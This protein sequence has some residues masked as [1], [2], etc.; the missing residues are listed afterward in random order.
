M[1]MEEQQRIHQNLV[2]TELVPIFAD[3][4]LIGQTI[5]QNKD[6]DGN[7]EKEGTISFFFFDMMTQKPVSKVVISRLTAQNLHKLLG[8]TIEKMNIEIK[9]NKETAVPV[10]IQTQDKHVGYIG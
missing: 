1:S 4:V 8:D 3:D 2:N 9:S 6:K 7:L 10:V 5:K